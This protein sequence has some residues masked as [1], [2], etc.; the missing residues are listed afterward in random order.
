MWQG[1]RQKNQLVSGNLHR[2]SGFG[3][4]A[5][6]IPPHSQEPQK[7]LA[8][9]QKLHNRASYYGELLCG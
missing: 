7:K 9:S 3:E 2:A 4:R 1:V 5:H 8:V 6:H